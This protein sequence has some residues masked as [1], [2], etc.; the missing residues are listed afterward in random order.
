M[1]PVPQF[2]ALEAR[3]QFGGINYT[4]IFR[5][6][7]GP[8]KAIIKGPISLGYRYTARPFFLSPNSQSAGYA[9]LGCGTVDAN[10][11]Q[12]K[13][14]QG[15]IRNFTVQRRGAAP[16]GKFLRLYIGRS[17]IIRLFSNE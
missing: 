17:L 4:V 11:G 1:Q 3:A 15:N 8:T 13:A 16:P 6:A 10:S 12:S 7:L 2:L 5:P 9:R 14:V